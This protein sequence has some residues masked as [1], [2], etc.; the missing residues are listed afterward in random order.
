[1]QLYTNRL[2]IRTLQASDWCA[3]Q[4]I[5]ADFSFSPVAVYDRLLPTEEEAIK[6]LTERFAESGLWFA[7][8]PNAEMIGYV[9][10]HEDADH[11]DLGYCFDSA[12]HG[13]GYALEACRALM[14]YIEQTR[15]IHCFTAGCAL[16]NTPSRKLL[17]KL[18][19]E[20]KST[21]I[22]AFNKDEQGRD[23][24]FEG[25]NFVKEKRSYF[26]EVFSY[27]LTIPQGKVVTYGQIAAHLGNPRLARVVGN[28]LHRNP[29][30]QKYPCYKVVNAQG[31]LAPSFV[32]GGIGCQ[33]EK[34]ERE[35]IE[36]IDNA[37]DLDKYQWRMNDQTTGG[38]HV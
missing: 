1:M 9:C 21:E 15:K 4:K 24:P 35:G 17:E 32:F 6:R 37:V 29:D 16:V 18:G 34:L 10:F 25:G 8:L 20:L 7:V 31:K 19:F 30:E 3:L 13:K 27:L 23:I 28:I 22:L 12:Y 38:N 36:V 5:A 33:K 26:E 11:C 14:S 2:M